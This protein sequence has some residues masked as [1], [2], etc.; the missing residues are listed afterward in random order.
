MRILTLGLLLLP[1]IATAEPA[2][3]GTAL[4]VRVDDPGHE[5]TVAALTGALRS[6]RA[7]GLDACWKKPGAMTMEVAFEGGKVARVTKVDEVG[8]D[9]DEPTAACVTRA[10]RAVTLASRADH[11]T[12]TYALHAELRPAPSRPSNPK[13]DQQAVDAIMDRNQGTTL[14]KFT[15]IRGNVVQG[16]SSAGSAQPGPGELDG[17]PVPPPHAAMID[18][19]AGPTGAF[20]DRSADAIRRVVVARAG[21]LRACYQKALH[22]TPG[23]AGAVVVAFSIEPN[24]TVASLMSTASTARLP[25]DI[26]SCI[27][28]NIHR[29]RFNATEGRSEVSYPFVFSES[30]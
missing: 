12:A 21:V 11:V 20:G 24:G 19:G 23:I 27:K 30:H 9:G 22:R 5:V 14:D 2:R 17:R 28:S 18:F 6:I 3:Y 1:A 13:A 29:L 16:S 15:G 4:D 25:E 26:A 7:T 10:L 8:T